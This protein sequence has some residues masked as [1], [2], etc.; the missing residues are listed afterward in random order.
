LAEAEADV[1]RGEGVLNDAE[2]R[3]LGSDWLMARSPETA[4]DM[5]EVSVDM[6]WHRDSLTDDAGPSM[7]NLNTDTPPLR[8]EERGV[9]SE[10]GPGV[11]VSE[12]EALG[13]AGGLSVESL[14]VEAT[15]AVKP[16]V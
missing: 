14:G 8:P 10:A 16:N 2:A 4:A 7:P 11:A 15:G 5:A 13:L 6:D 12:D 3:C 1:L 9:T